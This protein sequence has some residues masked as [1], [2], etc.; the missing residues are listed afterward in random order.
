MKERT[1]IFNSEMNKCINCIFFNPLNN[2]LEPIGAC[3][4][5]EFLIA[6]EDQSCNK[7]KVLEFKK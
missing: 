2:G 5:S 6:H 4:K 7:F 3:K 1:V